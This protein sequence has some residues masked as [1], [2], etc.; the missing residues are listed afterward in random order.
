MSH[1]AP[2]CALEIGTTKVVALVGELCDDG[3]VS[4][5]GIGEQP[6]SGV[7]KGEI[8]DLENAEACVRAAVAQAAKS[9]EGE[10]ASV[11]LILSGGHFT[12]ISSRGSILIAE[13]E[14]SDEDIAKVMEV[15]SAVSMPPERE[16]LHT[17]RQLFTVDGQ[18]SVINPK[19]ME[20]AK[21]A[22]DMCIIHGVRARVKNTIKVV[23]SAGFDVDDAKFGGLCSAHAVLT[24]EQRKSGA[25]VLD[26]GGGTT[27]YVVMCDNYVAMAGALGMGGDHITNDIAMAFKIPT[28]Q[29]EKLKRE[30]GSALVDASTASHVVELPEETGFRANKVNLKSLHTVINARMDEILNT[31]RKRVEKEDLLHHVGSG[32]FITGGTGHLRGVEHLAA[33]VFGLPGDIGVPRNVMGLPNAIEVPEYAAVCGLIHIAFKE[34]IEERRRTTA[35]KRVKDFLGGKL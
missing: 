31:I 4:V 23:K 22:L 34:A 6:S 13:S 25:L 15:A 21:L 14:I 35:W 8:V 12:S 2:V 16:K 10:L 3:T 33:R 20:G 30:H 19:G 27:D 9:C 29:A 7:R 1:M 28:L 11:R 24:P 5:V 17:I 26:I 18:D 32:V